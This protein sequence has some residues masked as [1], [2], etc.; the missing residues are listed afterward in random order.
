MQVRLALAAALLIL[1][2][3]CAQISAIG[4]DESSDAQQEFLPDG[5]P[6]VVNGFY[7]TQGSCPFEGCAAGDLYTTGP[8][9]LLERP[10]L[11]ARVVATAPAGEWVSTEGNI[12]RLRPARG[13]VV[14]E[15]RNLYDSGNGVPVLE[16]GDV[17]YAI[18]VQGE[19]MTTLWRRGE[20]MSW[21]DMDGGEV[22]DG[23]RWTWSTAE[24]RAADEAAGGGWWLELVRANGE[25]GW[26]RDHGNL[27]CLGV[28]DASPRCEA[29]WAASRH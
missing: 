1:V 22:S 7:E 13:V 14:G 17:V 2:S 28:I 3:A 11:D 6:P 26:V 27:D 18:D 8:V 20:L 23:I 10:A 12:Y 21:W 9:A 19:G 25:R 4:P 29:H 16:I 15:V 5:G 24:Q